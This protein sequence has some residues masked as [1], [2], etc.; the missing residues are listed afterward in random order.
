MNRVLVFLA[1]G[2]LLAGCNR[3]DELQEAIDL[4]NQ[5]AKVGAY[6]EAIR[7]YES[8]LDGTAKTADVH[9]KIAVI[10]D[11]KLKI[12]LSAIHHYD[13]Y[14]ELAPGGGRA[15]EAKSARADCDKRMNLA[16]KTGG[17]MTT[18]EGARLQNE[19]EALRRQ[20]AELR[21]PKPAPAPR[22][23]NPAEP[24]RSPPGA[25]KHLVAKGET[26]ASIAFKFYRSRAQAA[27]IRDANFNQ[28]HG[29][30]VIKPGM[31][32]IIPALPAKKRP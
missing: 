31:T 1:L 30:D 25:R 11:E 19:N 20:I 18:S 29:S 12:P 24:D 2:C 9:Y 10:Y 6:R 15:K 5:R 27:R 21:N 32:L 26:L 23:P 16:M 3:Q 13:R 22:V 8:A 17:F 4:G 14:L 7:S 28:L